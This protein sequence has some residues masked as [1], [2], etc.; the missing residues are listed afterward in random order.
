MT[1]DQLQQTFPDSMLNSIPGPGLIVKE[2]KAMDSYSRYYV[3]G[4]TS[5][6]GIKYSIFKQWTI[7]NI[8]QIIG[9]ANKQGWSVDKL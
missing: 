4:F 3:S 7:G 8:D 1:L 2:G 6:D 9:F 5:S